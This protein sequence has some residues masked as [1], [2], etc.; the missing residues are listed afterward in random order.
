M[1]TPSA[2]Q[3]L[4]A[5]FSEVNR[6]AARLR[7]GIAVADGE[8]GFPGGV[9]GVLQTLGGEGAQTVP[10]I[11]RTRGTSR[12]NIQVV[13]NRLKRTGLVQSEF[14]PVHKRSALVRLTEKG[15]AAHDEIKRSESRRL[16]S[17]V[18]KVPEQD[19]VSTVR[20]LNQVRQLLAGPAGRETASEQ[21]KAGQASPSKTASRT[22]RRGAPQA[23]V[24]EDSQS[25]EDAFPLN[26]L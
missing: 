2:V 18:A 15:E 22:V 4:G 6:L 21:I 13:I 14:N 1:V 26:L 3:L 12:Q 19:V 9:C 23:P 25:P 10:D 24:M 5:L 16:E 17:L 20:V 7:H 8:D 11:A